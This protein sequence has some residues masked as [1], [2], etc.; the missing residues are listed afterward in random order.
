MLR[1]LPTAA[2]IGSL[3]VLPGAHA[4]ELT[5]TL[6]KIKEWISSNS[7]GPKDILAKDRVQDAGV[8]A[9]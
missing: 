2:V 1:L 9:P 8:R 7:K 4:Q 5:G 3:F 6:K